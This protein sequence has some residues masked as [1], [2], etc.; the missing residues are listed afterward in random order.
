L[1]ALTGDPSL[2]D[3]ARAIVRLL[4]GHLR[5]HP[6]AVTTALSALDVMFSGA[7]EIVISGDRDDLVTEVQRR[8]LPRAVLAWGEP[9]DSPLWVGRDEPAAYVCRDFVCELPTTT[10]AA[11]S[12]QLDR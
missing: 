6:T 10:V 3:R 7:T 9:Y 1:A 5:H 11:L 8:Y 2:D 4:Q 12:A